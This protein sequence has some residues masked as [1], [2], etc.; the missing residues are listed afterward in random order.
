[1][2]S[3]TCCKGLTCGRF[4]KNCTIAANLAIGE[5]CTS[6]GQCASGRCLNYCTKP[7]S[8]TLEFGSANYCLDTAQGFLCVPFCKGNT[9][10]AVFGLGITC[11]G[12]KDPGGLSLN[13]CFGL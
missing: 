7:C 1:V 4:S 2:Y 5:P 11:Q 13:G 6:N 8:S 3:G 12:S 10:C 9:D